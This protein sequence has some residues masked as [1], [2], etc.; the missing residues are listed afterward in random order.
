MARAEEVDIG[1]SPVE[2]N[3]RQLNEVEDDTQQR[4]RRPPVIYGFDEFAKYGSE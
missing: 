1:S 4:D 2:E 3:H